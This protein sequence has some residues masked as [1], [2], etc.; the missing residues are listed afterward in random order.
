MDLDLDAR[1]A[2]PPLPPILLPS[3]AH[4]KPYSMQ[5]PAWVRSNAGAAVGPGVGDAVLGTIVG[6]AK[7]TKVGVSS[8]PDPDTPLTGSEVSLVPVAAAA[9]VMCT[10]ATPS[11]SNL[12]MAT[13]LGLLLWVWLPQLL[14]WYSAICFRGTT[15]KNI[16]LR[17][18]P[19]TDPVKRP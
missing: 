3:R 6:C 18:V 12:G 9:A 17:E 16:F 11:S 2:T 8:S 13:N 10:S 1:Q 15:M 4:H 5:G 14:A 19:L 7:G